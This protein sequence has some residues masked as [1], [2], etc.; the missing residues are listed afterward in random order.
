M[1][2]GFLGFGFTFYTYFEGPKHADS[3]FRFALAGTGAL[4]T[5]ELAFHCIDT[6]NMRSKAL[7]GN[8]LVSSY[9]LL[10]IE[11]FTSLFRGIT[12][13]F[14][15]YLW[16]SMIYFYAYAKIRD[17]FYENWRSYNLL[18]NFESQNKRN[19]IFENSELTFG[20]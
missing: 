20:Q 12:A 16:S 4:L 8:K 5:V 10:R 3:Y 17:W 9:K 15:G 2:C 7:E 18:Q 19:F 14:H 6:L 13:V 11:N 1:S